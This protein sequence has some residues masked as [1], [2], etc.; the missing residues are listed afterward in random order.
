[1][2]MKKKNGFT[3][4]ELLVSLVLITTLSIALFKV[5]ANI[6]KKE[7]INIARNSLTAFKAVLNNNIETDFINDTITELYSCGDNCFDIT[8]KN[9]GKVRL[10]LEDN[11]ITYGSM[12]EEIPKN[13]KLYSN[14]SITFYESDEE[15]K[16]AYVL[17]TIPIKG[18]LEKGFENIK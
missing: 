1:M 18:D 11:I 9:K 16:N 13:Y 14:M 8:Y 7:Q 15:N 12:K 6:Q 2:K 3:M 4:V 5:V 17:L 10:N